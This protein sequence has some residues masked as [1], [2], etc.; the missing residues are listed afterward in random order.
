LSR[1]E[2]DESFPNER[3]SR[4]KNEGDAELFHQARIKWLDNYSSELADRRLDRRNDLKRL[5]RQDIVIFFMFVIATSLGLLLVPGGLLLVVLG[6][7]VFGTISSFAGMLAG[8][9]II[10]LKMTHSRND[11]QRKDLEFWESEDRRANRY[12]GMVIMSDNPDQRLHMMSEMAKL[13]LQLMQSDLSLNGSSPKTARPSAELN[14][15]SPKELKTA[16]DPS[17][18]PADGIAGAD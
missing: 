18:S 12:I 4:S 11:R 5:N 3:V 14:D 15:S 10:P 13:Q 2:G 1:R 9:S 8:V 7:T 16:A 17:L 6:K